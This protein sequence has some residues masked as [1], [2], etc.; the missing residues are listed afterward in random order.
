MQYLF[1]DINGNNGFS[2][3]FSTWP[4]VIRDIRKG[5]KLSQLLLGKELG[6]SQQKVTRYEGGTE[7]PLDFWQKFSE[8]FHINLRWLLF[9]EGPANKLDLADPSMLEH[10]STTDIKAEL[11]Q[12]Q[13][14]TRGLQARIEKRK[15]ELLAE[16]PKLNESFDHLRKRLSEP[17]ADLV[18]NDAPKWLLDDLGITKK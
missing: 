1:L 2:V 3:Q 10:I 16:G 5:H 14:I 9:G 12:R 13:E 17:Q 15:K 7:P 6:Y 4:Q 8:K 18:P 11:K